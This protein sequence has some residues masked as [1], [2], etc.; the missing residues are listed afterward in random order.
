MRVKEAARCARHPVKTC[1]IRCPW[2]QY[3]LALKSSANCG[4][5]LECLRACP[6]D[7]IAISLRPWGREFGPESRSRLDEAFLGLVMLSSAL[8]DA[9]IF[10]GPWGGIK[11]AAYAVGSQ[12]WF[13]FAGAFLVLALLVFPGMYAVSVLAGQKL[14]GSQAPLRKAME[15][16]SQVLI[17]LGLAAWI[18]FTVAFAFTKASYI[19]AVIADPF[20]WGWNLTGAAGM[21]AAGQASPFSMLVQ[22]VLL[23]GGLAW[24]A[25]IARRKA[26][27]LKTAA[28]LIAFSALFSLA[29]LWLLVG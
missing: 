10:L 3:P 14:A 6:E 8:V 12:S 18:A 29:M 17:P 22:V 28:P 15:R 7:N 21:A 13:I 19:P 27:Y 25:R 26:G 5:C 11:A 23:A 16:Q 4:L 9:A 2:G 24:A 1:Y 20:G